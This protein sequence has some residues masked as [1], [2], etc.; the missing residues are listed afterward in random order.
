[1]KQV[2]NDQLV[3]FILSGG[4]EYKKNIVLDNSAANYWITMMQPNFLLMQTIV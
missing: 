3:C 1:M 4:H 2:L